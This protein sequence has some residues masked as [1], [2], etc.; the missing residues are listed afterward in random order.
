MSW[1]TY[2]CFEQLGPDKYTS[3]IILKIEASS[4]KYPYLSPD[5]ALWLTLSGSNLLYPEKISMFEPLKFDCL[6]KKQQKTNKQ[7]TKHN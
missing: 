5:L 4:L 2:R 3:Y 1:L 6:K 7:T